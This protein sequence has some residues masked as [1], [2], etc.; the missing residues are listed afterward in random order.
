MPNLKI[1]DEK[2]QAHK[3]Q[4][5]AFLADWEKGSPQDKR[6]ARILVVQYAN[7]N[8]LHS[9]TICDTCTEAHTF[10]QAVYDLLKVTKSKNKE[11]EV[12]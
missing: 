3:T 4:L 12:K 10:T 2:I 8:Y 9:D 6:K 5:L 11:I 7:A 1:N